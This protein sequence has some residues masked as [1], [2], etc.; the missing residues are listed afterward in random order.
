MNLWLWIL[1]ACALAYLTKLVGYFVPAK[2]LE[3]PRIM[4]VAGTMTIGLLASLT[5]VNAVASGQG[6]VLDARIGALAAA[7]VALWLRAPFL[8]V[9]I[10][11]AAAAALLRLLGW[12]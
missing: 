4:H 9:V 5:V 10:S 1:I 8:V 6:L 3:S 12:G 7:A 2:L 11:G